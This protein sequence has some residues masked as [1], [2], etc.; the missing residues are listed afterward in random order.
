VR[1][2]GALPSRRAVLGGALA[3]LAAPAL[4]A[5]TGSPGGPD[6]A[7]EVPRDVVA[8]DRA[9]ERERQLVA[10]YDAALV[11]A[12]ALAERLLP[13]RADHEQHLAALGQPEPDPTAAPT[14]GP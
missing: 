4:A 2:P 13:L 10:A 1:S 6:D 8:A 12:P 9:V 11:I 7:P 5:C 14:A 3:G